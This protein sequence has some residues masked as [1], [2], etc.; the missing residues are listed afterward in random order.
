MEVREADKVEITVL[1]DNYTDLFLP[2]TDRVQRVPL[3]KGDQLANP[4]LAEHGLSLFVKAHHGKEC[5]SVLLDA[6]WS[7]VGVPYNLQALEID[8]QEIEAGVASHGHPDHCGAWEEVL[9]W[10]FPRKIPWVVH[11]DAFLSRYLN[12]PDGRKINFSPPQQERLKASGAELCL[13]RSPSHLG[14][15]LILVTGEVERSTDFE[16]GLPNAFAVREGKTEHD[17][18]LDD[19]ALVLQVRGKGLVV[20]S[21]CAHAGIINTVRYARKVTGMDRVYAVIGGFHLTGPQFEPLIDRTI[22]ELKEISPEMI[23]PMH[24]T[25]WKT[26]QRI[27]AELPDSFVPSCVGTKINL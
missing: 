7:R 1:M 11:P 24:C 20:I 25:G 9:N 27:G 17:P 8:P 2:G 19:Q 23:I 22:Q 12:L 13:V 15:N 26:I 5:H 4:L 10:L 21:G 6:G 18:I 14:G 3:V 16:K